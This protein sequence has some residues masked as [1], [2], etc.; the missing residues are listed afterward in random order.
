M[1]AK[2]PL[3]I[4]SVDKTECVLLFGTFLCRPHASVQGF[5]NK[6]N[7]RVWNFLSLS[8]V[9]SHPKNSAPG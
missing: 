3:V 7:I 4:N 5:M 8:E 9:E 2:L 1:L 6:M